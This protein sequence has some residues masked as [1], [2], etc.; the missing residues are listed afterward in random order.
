MYIRLQYKI[1]Q[2][3]SVFFKEYCDGPFPGCDVSPGTW[4]SGCCSTPIRSWT[5]FITR[6]FRFHATDFPVTKFVSS[7]VVNPLFNISFCD[8]FTSTNPAVLFGVG[9]CSVSYTHLDVYKRQP[10]RRPNSAVVCCCNCFC[11][12]SKTASVLPAY[13]FLLLPPPV[14][15]FSLLPLHAVVIIPLSATCLLY[16][17]RCV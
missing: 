16:T 9:F 3:T 2:E 12:A 6:I 15:I 14:G 17:S 10:Y 13:V 8:V 7:L 1:D 5:F 4:A 11:I